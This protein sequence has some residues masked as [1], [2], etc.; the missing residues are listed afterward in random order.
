MS[1]KKGFS[2][3]RAAGESARAGRKWLELSDGELLA[4]CRVETY[5]ASGPGGQKR[6]KTSSAVRLH[7]EPTG[8]T[9][10]ATESR[11]QH[12]NRARALRRLRESIALNVRDPVDPKAAPPPFVAEAL[13][14][15]PGLHV[16]RR[17]PDFYR[18][19][20]Y[21]L[22]VLAHVGGSPARAADCLGI[23]TSQL[24]RFLKTEPKL[25]AHANQLR[26]ENGLK[27]LL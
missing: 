19:V 27:F 3:A 24:V 9:V 11:S 2:D 12:E 7:H 13:K 15:G 16:S 1:S 17:H 5:R 14:R 25:L 10:T 21:V 23:T 18:I 26:R 6:N 4:Q 20:H 8:L 22:D